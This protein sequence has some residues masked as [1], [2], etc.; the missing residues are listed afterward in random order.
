MTTAVAA[1]PAPQL[2]VARELA[3]GRVPRAR[4]G[5]RAGHVREAISGAG[6][7]YAGAVAVVEGTHLAGVVAIEDLL[8]ASPDALMAELMDRAPPTIGSGADEEA[9]V[10][11]TVMRGES[12]VVVEGRSGEFRGLIPPSRLL[13]VLLHE[14]DEDLARLGGYLNSSAQARGAAEEG[15]VDRLWHRIPWLLLGLAG[16]MASAVI[17]GG[18]EE[19]LDKTVLLAFF[20]PAVVYMADAVGTQTETVLIRGLSVGVELRKV[21]RRELATG[22]IVGLLMA[23]AFLPFALLVWGDGQVAAAVG[24]ALLASCTIA[25]LVAM[26]FPWLFHHFGA[27]PAFGSGPLATVVQDLLSITVYLFIATLVVGA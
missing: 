26:V 19:Q 14:H 22:L 21:V 13:G 11:E 27:D 18:F 17:V 7:E 23:G 4:P 1:E 2:G 10:W 8:K 20:L 15:V 6:Y 25:T 5:Q 3:T 24:L 9:V 12:T 16:A